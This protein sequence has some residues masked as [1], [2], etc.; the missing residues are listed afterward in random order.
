MV[1]R[2]SSEPAHHSRAAPPAGSTPK[3]RPSTARSQHL[4]PLRAVPD[5]LP[6]L[7]RAQDRA[8]LAARAHLPDARS[9]RGPRRAHARAGRAPRQ[10][11]RLP[12]VRDRVSGGRA[13]RPHARADARATGAPL[14]RRRR[15]GAW[16]GTLG[17]ALADPD[18]AGACSSRPTSCGSARAGP[19]AAFMRSPLA[20]RL[21]PRVRAPGL[22]DDAADRSRAASARSS[23]LAARLPAGREPRAPIGRHAGVPPGRRAAGARRVLHHAA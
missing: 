14:D 4:H 1:G 12:R 19:I 16:L 21:L 11:P 10:L 22:G 23:A 6:D 3:T 17:A 9:G 5:R 7:S 15:R 13:V 20:A 2:V 18:I 8:R